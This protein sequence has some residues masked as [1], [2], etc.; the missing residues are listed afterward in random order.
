MVK[1]KK[2][3]GG[4]G[5]RGR[6]GNLT[7]ELFAEGI[8]GFAAAGHRDARDHERKVLGNRYDT[9]ELQLKFVDRRYWFCHW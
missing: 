8:A 5:D 2:M 7:I 9:G 6:G 3:G 1:C 4:E